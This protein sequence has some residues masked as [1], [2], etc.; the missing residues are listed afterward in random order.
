MAKS[1]QLGLKENWKQFTIGAIISGF[2]ADMFG[3]EY[4]ILIIEIL[5]IISALI[6]AFRIPKLI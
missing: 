5:T 3:I 4:A 2:T 6:I 1:I